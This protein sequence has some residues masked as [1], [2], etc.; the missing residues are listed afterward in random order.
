MR[1][2]ADGPLQGKAMEICSLWTETLRENSGTA[3]EEAGPFPDH[4]FL[5]LEVRRGFLG[6]AYW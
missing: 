1:Q 6:G 4:I 5:V 2:E 3:M